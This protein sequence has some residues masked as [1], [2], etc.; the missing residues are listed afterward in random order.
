LPCLLKNLHP[1]QSEDLWNKF[2]VS[3]LLIRTST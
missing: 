3:M 2:N 1:T